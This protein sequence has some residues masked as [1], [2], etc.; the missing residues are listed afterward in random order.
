VNPDV[1]KEIPSNS[2]EVQVSEEQKVIESEKNAPS[3]SPSP[4]SLSKSEQV[5]IITGASYQFFDSLANLVGSIHYWEPNR[6]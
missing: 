1:I 6:R 5:A 3:S 4:L 2:P